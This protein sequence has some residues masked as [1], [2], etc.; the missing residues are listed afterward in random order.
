MTKASRTTS[1]F[2]L[3]AASHCLRAQHI[4]AHAR[5]DFTLFL[6]VPRCIFP[7]K[8]TPAIEKLVPQQPIDACGLGNCMSRARHFSLNS[9][10]KI[11]LTS[12]S[13]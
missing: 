9:T 10:E 7:E 2:A 11:C 4:N 13:F 12:P 1:K 6:G 8:M 5:Y 3:L